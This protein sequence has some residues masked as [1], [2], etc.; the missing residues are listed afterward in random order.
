[1][2]FKTKSTEYNH[3][4]DKIRETDL[5]NNDKSVINKVI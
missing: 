4:K 5:K 1:M 2:D 3:W